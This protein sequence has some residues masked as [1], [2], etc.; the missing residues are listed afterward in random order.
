MPELPLHGVTPT[1]IPAWPA[2]TVAAL[3]A[4][5]AADDPMSALRDVA[6][7]APSFLPVWA[8]LAE[9]S[10]D[11]G[12]PIGAY[13]FARVGYHRG[14]D[15][16][17]GAGWRGQGPAPWSHEPNR[18]FLRSLDALRRAAAAIGEPG[19]PERCRDF[20]LQLDPEDHLGV[21]GQ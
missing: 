10:L 20:L 1:H 7:S 16:I 17:R 4:A 3:E 19:E 15:A 14:L 12:D 5:T 9:R 2:D 11:A 21:A 8:E 18:G 13:A 6:A